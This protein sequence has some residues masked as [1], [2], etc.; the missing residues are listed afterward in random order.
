M[1]GKVL[2]AMSGGVDSS[3]AAVLVHK[4]IEQVLRHDIVILVLLRHGLGGL[5]GLKTLLRIILCVHGFSFP[6]RRASYISSFCE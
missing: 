2:V 3:V 1:A 6:R 4:G 5:D